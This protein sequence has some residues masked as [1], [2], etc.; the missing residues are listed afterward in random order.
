MLKELYSRARQRS[1]STRL[2]DNEPP[3]YEGLEGANQPQTEA[4]AT[5]TGL[6]S[7][8]RLLC[9]KIS[10][11]PRRVVREAGPTT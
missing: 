8:P 11:R 4:L 7:T 9:F 3:C 2:A 1:A 10:K 6:T 5:G